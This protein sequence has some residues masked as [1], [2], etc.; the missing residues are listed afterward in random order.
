MQRNPYRESFR[1]SL[2]QSKRR[3]GM[4]AGLKFLEKERQ[5]IERNEWKTKVSIVHYRKENG[6][7][8]KERGVYFFPRNGGCVLH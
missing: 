6:E 2:E 4:E 7:K 8:T 1:Q 3:Q 5:K